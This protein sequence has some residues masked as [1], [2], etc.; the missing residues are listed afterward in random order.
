MKLRALLTPMSVVGFPLARA[1]AQLC[2]DDVAGRDLPCACG[3]TV[4]SNAALRD[5]SVLDARSGVSSLRRIVAT[6]R[7]NK[8][9]TALPPRRGRS[10]LESRRASLTTWIP[11]RPQRATSR[12]VG[13]SCGRR[14]FLQRRVHDQDHE[15]RTQNRG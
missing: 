7:E 1:G 15:D 6:T 10:A 4:V 9:P 3:H 13:R 8:L 11:S 5:D 14:I 12:V 2:S